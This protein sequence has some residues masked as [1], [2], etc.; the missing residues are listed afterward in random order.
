MFEYLP[1]ESKLTSPEL[2]TY[3]T[4]GLRVLD[5]RSQT[6][7]VIVIRDISTDRSFVAHLAYVYNRNQ[8]DP[9]HLLDVLEDLL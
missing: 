7:E 4:F 1:I 3:Q 5:H 6:E 2:G 9:V 8:L